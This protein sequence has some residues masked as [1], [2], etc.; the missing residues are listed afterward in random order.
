LDV[1]WASLTRRFASPGA[2]FV[3]PQGTAVVLTDRF[4]TAPFTLSVLPRAEPYWCNPLSPYLLKYRA[5]I[6]DLTVHCVFSFTFFPF[7]DVSDCSF[8][9]P[10]GLRRQSFPLRGDLPF[11]ALDFFSSVFPRNWVEL[12][13]VSSDRARTSSS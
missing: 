13:P 2:H 7:L 5:Q 12:F 1:P 8:F 9:S 3:R 4:F 10:C 6:P 11:G